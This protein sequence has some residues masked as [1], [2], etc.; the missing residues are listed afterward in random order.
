MHYSYTANIRR[1][2]DVGLMLVER[3]RRWANIKETLGRRLIFAR[4]AN[5]EESVQSGFDSKRGRMTMYILFCQHKRKLL[6]QNQHFLVVFLLVSMVYVRCIVP[7]TSNPGTI[8]V[9]L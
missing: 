4:Q 3:R 2:S 8:L 6:I 9:Q 1:R 5:V 7:S